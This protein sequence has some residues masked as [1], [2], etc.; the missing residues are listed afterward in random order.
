MPMY[1]FW[2]AGH[3]CI[4]GLLC[5]VA[6]AACGGDD[7][8][9]DLEKDSGMN[10]MPDA[11]APVNPSWTM[12][13]YDLGNSQLNPS[14]SK[15]SKDSVAQLKEA[16]RVVVGGG[17]TSTP[18]VV[19]GVVY[20]GGWDGFF[21]ATDAA[22]GALKWKSH[23]G[24]QYVRSSPLLTGDRIYIAADTSLFALARSD[25]KTLFE[26]PLI[27]HPQGFIE[28]SPKLS[29]GVIV[30]GL[31]SYELNLVKTD[32]TF[33]GSVVGVDADTGALLWKFMVAGQNDGPCKGGSGV[34]VWSSAAIDPAL[35][36][37][38]IGTGQ[39]YEAPASSC[40]DTLLA[41]HYKKDHQGSRL[42]WKATYTAE[43]VY[44][45]ADGGL[46]GLDH[47]IGAAPNLFRAGD[48]EAV[49]AG[50]KGGTY[51]A[52]NRRTGEQLWRADLDK[53]MTA[54]LGGVMVTAAADQDSV[55]VSSNSWM[56]FGFVTTGM[57]AP[58][59]TATLYALNTK[60]GS[61]RWKQMLDTP[62]F[63]TFGLVNGVLFHPNIRG[64][65]FARDTATG[66]ELW[67]AETGGP[68]GSG[69]AIADDSVYVS[70]G[71]AV[72]SKPGNGNLVRYALGASA[73]TTTDLRETTFKDLTVAECQTALTTLQ[74]DATCRSCL[75]ECNASTAGSC[76]GGCWAQVPCLVQHCA[77]ESFDGASG[78]ACYADH[79]SSKLLP[80]NVY[81]ESIRSAT[82]VLTCASMCNN[83]GVAPPAT[84]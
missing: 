53:S 77:K 1:S 6:L 2:A 13:G 43:D 24:R 61:V 14:P 12:Y 62:V 56:L 16:F 3:G 11:G 25:G 67:K 42:A 27:D 58:S 82:C 83:F 57:H 54:Q 30:L 45:A 65:L 19:D 32:Y 49:G 68:I 26:T 39:T 78:P 71:F 36:I 5:A 4:R 7:K 46:N 9:I 31:A 84:M 41:L 75:C 18:I 35:G 20:F 76:Q 55:Y 21:Y 52:F 17:A 64:V 44:V 48:V 37:A 74:P 33:D 23:I 80:P 73:S 79:C 66:N 40:N 47:D 70:A 81:Q 22:T 63:G 15:I 60:D 28:S 59:D 34:S 69:L 38:Y 50:D 8:K 72:G 29:D 10:L 51:R